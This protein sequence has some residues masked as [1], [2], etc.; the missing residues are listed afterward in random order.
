MRMIGQQRVSF[1]RIAL[2]REP[3]AVQITGGYSY[4]SVFFRYDEA[5]DSTG[6][7]LPFPVSPSV[8]DHY[9]KC[10]AEFRG[11]LTIIIPE[12]DHHGSA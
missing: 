1:L 6:K 9:E 10:I 3:P 11:F 2:A 8:T 4:F 7:R 5:Y 12:E